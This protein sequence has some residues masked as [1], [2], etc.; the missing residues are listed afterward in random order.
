LVI[1]AMPG[2]QRHSWLTS[3]VA[4]AAATVV[5]VAASA[6]TAVNWGIPK[7]Q[8]YLN[9][10]FVAL[11]A[12]LTQDNKDALSALKK[13]PS[14]ENTA[15]QIEALN[16]K[17]QQTN[18]TLTDIQK[19]ISLAANKGEL[20]PLD[21]KLDKA[22][23]ALAGIQ[24]DLSRAGSA[25]DADTAARNSTL[26]RIGKAV[27]SVNEAMAGVAS[28]AKLQD[29]AAKLDA[30]QAS[31]AR[32][33][34]AVKEGFAGG[35]SSRAELKDA[36]GKLAQPGA[37]P[38][39]AAAK[40]T[41]EDL[42]VLYVSLPGAPPAQADAMPPMSV[43]FERIGSAGDNGQTDP[44]IRKLRPIIKAHK[45][46][47]IAVSGHTD[48]LGSDEANHALSKKRAQ[49][50]A[51]KLKAAFAGENVEISNT[52]WGERRLKEW[53]PDDTADATNRRVDIV[54]RCA[55]A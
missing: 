37:A 36:V 4:A 23:A 8:N 13:L 3:A 9:E 25:R 35:A 42:V 28:Q 19:Q 55:G 32:I 40:K 29:A 16:S 6:F 33:E 54:V 44:I 24:A 20:A 2:E 21:A 22:N 51:A 11:D 10:R 26:G 12:K 38:A 43:Q 34:S 47:S 46:C 31:L 48:T 50:I 1:A 14:L 17:I 39:A 15:K 18:A 30:A 45:S 7:A 27:D 52:A 49:E 53:T 41:G 5:I